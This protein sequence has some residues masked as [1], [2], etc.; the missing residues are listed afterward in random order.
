MW[1]SLPRVSTLNTCHNLSVLESLTKSSSND[2]LQLAHFQEGGIGHLS[3][4]KK[5]HKREHNL[6]LEV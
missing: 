1:T 6:L 4:C 2:R 5:T 3:K